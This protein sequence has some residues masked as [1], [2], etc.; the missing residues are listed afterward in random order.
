MPPA[1]AIAPPLAGI[2]YL[3]SRALIYLALFHLFPILVALQSGEYGAAY[4]FIVAA[5]LSAFGGGALTL[6]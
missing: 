6:A 3:L 4:A 1:V 5:L 2:G